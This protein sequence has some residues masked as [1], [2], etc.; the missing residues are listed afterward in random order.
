MNAMPVLSH[1]DR[2][3]EVH[4]TLRARAA[5]FG[6]STEA[7]GADILQ[8]AVRPEGQMKLGSLLAEIG[9]SLDGVDLHIQRDKN[10]ADLPKFE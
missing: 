4:C 10:P 5:T 2:P 9:R 1:R 6:R 8:N 7:E 3:D